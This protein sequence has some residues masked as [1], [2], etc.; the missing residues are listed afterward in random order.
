MKSYLLPHI[1]LFLGIILSSCDPLMVFDSYQETENERW[2][3]GDIK[4]FEVEMTE[5]SVACNVL[6]N[7]RHTT[8]YP[9]SNL[10][11]FISVEGPEGTTVRDTLEIQITD[12]RGK[13]KGYGFGKIKHISRMYRKN[14]RFSQ[15]G[16]YTFFIEQGMR[17]TEV[18]V[19]DVGLRIEEFKDFR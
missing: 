15:P 2:K 1:C 6:I 11:V 17:Q 19:T 9:V 12:E 14:I 16:K 10:F 5:A 8:D 4:I 18:P 7:I 3:H 13:W